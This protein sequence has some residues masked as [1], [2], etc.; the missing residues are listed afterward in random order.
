MFIKIEIKCLYL[1]IYLIN[2]YYSRNNLCANSCDSVQQ[3][4]WI[5]K[6]YRIYNILAK[7]VA[8]IKIS[9]YTFNYIYIPYILYIK[10]FVNR[11]WGHYLFL[12]EMVG[13]SESQCAGK[14]KVS[15]LAGVT[16]KVKRYHWEHLDASDKVRDGCFISA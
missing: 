13:Q 11:S 15:R 6:V 12:R 16:K 5:K 2:K 9:L 1:I 7:E 8:Y 4:R 3:F 14:C 10:I